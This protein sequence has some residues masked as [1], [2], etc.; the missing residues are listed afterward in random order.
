MT[1]EKL[2]EYKVCHR[3]FHSDLVSSI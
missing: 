3:D 2:E 1:S